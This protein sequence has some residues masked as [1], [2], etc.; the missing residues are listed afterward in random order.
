VARCRERRI[1]HS[2]IKAV[3]KQSQNIHDAKTGILETRQILKGR[4]L[5]A[6]FKVEEKEVI[7]ITA[8]Y[9]HEN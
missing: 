2:D 3:V 9:D 4:R 8:Y 6:I 1:R 5:T 7:I